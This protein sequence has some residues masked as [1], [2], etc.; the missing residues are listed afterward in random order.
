MR[1]GRVGKTATCRS[2]LQQKNTGWGGTSHLESPT[3]TKGGL[4]ERMYMDPTA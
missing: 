3:D 1:I 4:G 2:Y